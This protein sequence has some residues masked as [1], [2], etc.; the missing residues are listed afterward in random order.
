MVKLRGSLD[1]TLLTAVTT[2][3]FADLA[4]DFGDNLLQVACSGWLMQISDG[5]VVLW[6][7]MS[8]TTAM[9]AISKRVG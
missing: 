2:S 3:K 6:E 1:D 8:G 4:L 7:E 5:G 9:A